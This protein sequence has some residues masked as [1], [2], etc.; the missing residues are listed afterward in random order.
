MADSPAEQKPNPRAERAFADYVAMG[1]GR[2][3]RALHEQYRQSSSNPPAK[4]L[5]TLFDWSVRYKWQARLEQAATVRAEAMLIE[6]MHIDSDTFLRSSRILNER[7]QL[8][9]SGHVDMV[10]KVRESVRKPA[11]KGGATVGVNVTVD[12][13]IQQIVERIAE[14][15]GLSADEILAEADRILEATT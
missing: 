4:S 15:S 8:A 6:A 5:D 3:L 9:T 10:V 7:M 14:E 2:S 12:V 13:A 1:D 11:P